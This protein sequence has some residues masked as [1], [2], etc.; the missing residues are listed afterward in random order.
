MLAAENPSVAVMECKTKSSAVG[1]KLVQARLPF[2]RLNPVLKENEDPLEGKKPNSLK[3]S[4]CHNDSDLDM[5]HDV[6]NECQLGSEQG[7]PHK[8]VTGKGS[9]DHFILKSA[10]AGKDDCKSLAIVDL[11]E[12]SNGITEAQMGQTGAIMECSAEVIHEGTENKCR[13]TDSSSLSDMLE[14]SV[15]KEPASLSYC[16]L[17]ASVNE[18][19]AHNSMNCSETVNKRETLIVNTGICTSQNASSKFNRS[20]DVL[21]EGRYPLVVL[22]DIMAVKSSNSSQLEDSI[23]T[24][25]EQE[26]KL[27]SFLG[28]D[29][30]ILSSASSLSASDSSPE[31]KAMK[32]TSDGPGSRTSTPLSKVKPKIAGGLKAHIQKEREEKR[33]KLQAEK[34]AREKL[35]DEAKAAKERAKEEAKRKRDE[36]KEMKEK[37]K[38]EKKE[39]DDKEK[40]ERLRLKE[41]KRKEKQ[42][43]IEAKLEEKKKK[44][45]EKRLKEEEKRVKAEKAEI[46][47][48][49]QKPKTPQ[50]PKI[51]AG[52]C[53]KFA[54]FE[55]KAN[56]VLAPLTRV[57]CDQDMT[58]QLDYNMH[59]QTTDYNYLK[60]LKSRKPRRSGPTCCKAGILSDVIILQNESAGIPNRKK[61]GKMKLLY[62]HENYRPAY[63]GTWSKNS[64]KISP[65]NPLSKDEDL[66]DYEVDSDE[67]WEEEEP[68][69]SLS[70]SEGDDEEE[71]GDDEDEDDGFFVP[72]GYLSDGEGATDEECRDLE[73]QKIRQKLKAKEWDELMTKEKKLCVLQPVVIG[74]VWEGNAKNCQSSEFKILQQ[75]TACILEVNLIEE[76]Q[77]QEACIRRAKR[78]EQIL[79]QLLPLLHGN[80]NGSK[81]IIQEFQEW[82]RHKSPGEVVGNPN[83]ETNSTSPVSSRPQTPV[84]DEDNSIPSKAKLKRLIS[85]NAVYE[86]R[87]E[88]RLRCWY[89]HTE[90]LKTFERENLPVPCHWNYL[91]Q[92][93]FPTV[94]FPA[95]EDISSPVSGGSTVVTTPVSVKRKSVGS[96][97]ITKFMKRRKGAEQSEVNEPDGFQADTE[98]DEDEDPD[99]MIVD[100]CLPSDAGP[101][102]NGT[103][104][105]V[106]GMDIVLDSTTVVPSVNI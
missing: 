3:I 36:E 37:E 10:V 89:V 83:N 84:V 78:D 17:D 93:P 34:E 86:K 71:G 90:V 47:R 65:R 81:S 61:F 80:V 26:S 11:T 60:E 104:A 21:L 73:K 31:G 53:G 40:A 13:S 4:P 85:E 77:I 16:K 46:T 98:E 95:K 58:K 67:E 32:E 100:V 68:G 33:Q 14:D 91:T 44:E 64:C 7:L 59:E 24:E 8:P 29:S 102:H 43:A 55:I 74:C 27:E 45:E 101:K 62:F 51:L 49:L 20:R 103:A 2:K 88:F 82:C 76:E 25:T 106:D 79:G 22:Q 15:V 18:D 1:K 63:W 96:M 99:C 9:L 57:T 52:S 50:A 41:E 70:H 54:P 94:P 75:Y 56:M 6:E 28:N 48:F 42:D 92:V 72:H 30:V 39:K 69:E 97:P 105:Q 87:P 5:S 19:G 66:L 23:L 35:K 38:K 12:D